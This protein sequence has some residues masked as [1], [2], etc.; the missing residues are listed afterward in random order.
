M[1]RWLEE[2]ATLDPERDAQRIVFIDASLEFPWD[3]QRSLELAFY[4][5]YAVP[6]IAEL[7]DPGHLWLS[8]SGIAA[9]P[10]DAAEAAERLEARVAASQITR[11][12]E[13]RFDIVSMTRTIYGFPGGPTDFRAFASVFGRR[14]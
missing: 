1:N 7:L 13:P 14:A 4:R 9:T 2:V 11:A 8:L 6:S 3:T 12:V 5:T 10:E